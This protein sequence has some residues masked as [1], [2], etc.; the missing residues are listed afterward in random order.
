MPCRNRP[1]LGGEKE[2]PEQVFNSPTASWPTRCTDYAAPDEELSEEG[3][4]IAGGWRWREMAA[5]SFLSYCFTA[6]LRSAGGI[7]LRG[8][9]STRMQQPGVG[10]RLQANQDPATTGDGGS[11]LRPAAGGSLL[12]A[13]TCR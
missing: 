13:S 10:R 7:R 11:T 3:N 4:Q 5:G 9:G 12:P 1:W 2:E 6:A 8:T